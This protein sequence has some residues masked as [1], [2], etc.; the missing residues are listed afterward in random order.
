MPI[1]SKPI[2]CTCENEF[3]DQN[4]GPQMRLHSKMKQRVST[5]KMW[6]CTVCQKEREAGSSGSST[7]SNIKGKKKK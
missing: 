3:Q 4:Y 7:V 1:T 5:D 2:K 6:R